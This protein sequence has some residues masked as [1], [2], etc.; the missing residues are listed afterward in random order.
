MFWP[1]DVRYC[2]PAEQVLQLGVD[3]VH[4]DFEARHLAELADLVVDLDLDLG[5]HLLDARRV[6]AAVGHEALERLTRDLA[7]HRI[8]PRQDH[9]LGRVVDDDVDAGDG[10]ERADVAPL[11]PDDAPLHVV[12]RQVHHRNGGLGDV[13]ARRSAGSR[14]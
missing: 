2:E 3:A 12:A 13:V 1:Y 8:E 14:A 11:A 4:A 6:D 7:P 10:L 5:D 9:R